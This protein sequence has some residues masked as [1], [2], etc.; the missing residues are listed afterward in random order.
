[1]GYEKKLGDHLNFDN[2]QQFS[3]SEI[4]LVQL[5]DFTIHPVVYSGNKGGIYIQDLK[6]R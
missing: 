5:D 1:M 6:K 4:A 3:Q 2:L